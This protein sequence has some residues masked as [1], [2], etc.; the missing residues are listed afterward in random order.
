MKIA[1][2]GSTGFIGSNLSAFLADKG[3]EVC[4]LKR[5]HFL[6][7]Q[8]EELIKILG[9][10]QVVINLAG[11]SINCRWTKRSM[12]DIYDS[13][14]FTTRDLVSAINS[15]DKKPSLFIS[16]SAVGIY[17]EEKILN[18]NSLKYNSNF[19]AQVC[20]DWE[21]E[22]ENVSSEVRLVIT[23]LGVVLNSNGGVLSLMIIPFRF[24][25]GGNI[26]NGKQG[27]S[28]IHLQDLLEA[29]WE[30]INNNAAKGVIHL[31]AP[32]LSDNCSFAKT[33]AR[34]LHRPALFSIPVFVF[35]LLYGAGHIIFTTGQKVYPNRLL[36]LGF[37]FRYPNLEAALKEIT[38]KLSTHAIH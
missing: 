27:F 11:T 8:R 3:I 21:K 25:V 26:G 16:T 31:T 34:I 35:K 38:N 5:S 4:G 15:L 7:E 30:I 36:K 10:C 28:W 18:E 17:S 32:Q 12:K 9:G 19:L 20:K 29:F 6:P 1:I 33:L 37:T 23:R 22:A 24:F 2:S 14:I 13:R